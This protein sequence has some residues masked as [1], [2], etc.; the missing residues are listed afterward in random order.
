[1]AGSLVSYGNLRPAFVGSLAIIFRFLL[2]SVAKN[3][4]PGTL[5]TVEDS[6]EFS[7]SGIWGQ[8]ST[9]PETD[10]KVFRVSDFKGD[11]RLDFD[12][13]P[14]RTIQENK[15]PQFRLV[16]GDILVVKSSGSATRVVSGRVAV[17]E[18]E[19]DRGYAASNFLMRLRPKKD[20]DPHYL[21]FALGSPLI[22]EQIANFVK[23]MTYPNLP[24]KSYRN[25]VIPVVPFT[26]QER[27]AAF[28]K[29]ALER[30]QL[31]ELPTYLDEQRR[32]VARIEELAAKIEEARILRAH[33]TEE[34]HALLLKASGFMTDLPYTKVPLG[35]AV[36]K[37][38]GVAYKSEDFS[39][40][41]GP[42]VVRL[43]EIG[44][45]SP[46]V[47]L[48]TPEKYPNVW[49]EPGD[50]VLAKTSFS[51]GAMCIWPGP[52]AVLNQNAIMLRA[53]PGLDQQFLFLWLKNQVFR[54]LQHQLADPNFYPYIREKDI[55][56]WEIPIPPL[57]EQGRIIGYLDNLQAKIDSLKKLQSETAAEL[58]ALL[59]SILS[60]AFR[61]EL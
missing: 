13:A 3:D 58:D 52:K 7:D 31:P 37:R 12:R 47:Y 59:P 32:I 44:T 16:P 19:D 18:P 54:F 29:A 15:K 21:A 23:T 25:L 27:I 42:P 35:R 8:E 60:R 45:K 49:L 33:A 2:D 24:Y 5:R 50:I 9:D 17:F 4:V 43:A 6:I 55:V 57:N 34:T 39:V 53:K 36:E 22:R 41:E 14:L 10:F 28:F 51:T 56:A 11:F 30:A 61:G 48:R 46:T 40:S 38:T 20:F 1:M 26:D